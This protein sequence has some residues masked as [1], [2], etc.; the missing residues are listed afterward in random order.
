MQ[1]LVE[2]HSRK[3]AARIFYQ[4]LVLKSHS[5]VQVQQAAPYEDITISQLKKK[6]RASA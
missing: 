3:E 5:V 2:G 4:L 1:T 6:A